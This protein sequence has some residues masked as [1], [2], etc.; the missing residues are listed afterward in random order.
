M[1]APIRL[2]DHRAD[3]FAVALTGAPSADA[4]EELHQAC[5]PA[6]IVRMRAEL[7]A[8]E[9]ELWPCHLPELLRLEEQ[10]EQLRTAQLE[11]ELG[12]GGTA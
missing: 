4:L 2:G 10:A 5:L 3:I 11:R 9:A 8:L 6:R 12:I 1:T 7:R